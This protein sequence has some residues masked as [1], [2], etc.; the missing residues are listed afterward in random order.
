[1]QGLRIYAK[2]EIKPNMASLER[3]NFPFGLK[4]LR[5]MVLEENQIGFSFLS[6]F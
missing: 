4:K 5:A 1:M 6:I 2:I 3:E